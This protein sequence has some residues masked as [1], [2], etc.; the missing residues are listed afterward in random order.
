MIGWRDVVRPARPAEH[1]KHARTPR[2]RNI[3]MLVIF[4]SRS[5]RLMSRR[6][7]S[8]DPP[9][10][11]VRRGSIR[12]RPV[13]LLNPGIGAPSSVLAFEHAIRGGHRNFW[14]LGACGGLKPDLRIG[15]VVL[16]EAAV[17]EEGTSRLYTRR[18]P[19]H[20]ADPALTRALA[21]AAART[22]IAVR[23]GR[24]W[25]TD[26]PYRE[27]D[28]KIRRHRAGG[29][30]CVDMEVSALFAVA[31]VR[32]V[33]VAGLLVVSDTLGDVRTVGWHWKAFRRGEDSAR[34]V[35]LEAAL[36]PRD[37]VHS[38]SAR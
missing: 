17:S 19:E 38:R 4:L 6:L 3:P 34:A 32:S 22:G 10:L 11:Q 36:G 7:G 26:A 13:A 30:L 29:V 37:A 15:D 12:G 21:D 33:R 28:A 9:L 31:R 24:V 25:T 20:A 2:N 18:G 27:T 5:R 8:S 23:R 35:L 16:A 14:F 1:V